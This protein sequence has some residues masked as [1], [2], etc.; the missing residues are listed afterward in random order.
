MYR[1]FVNIDF[2]GK[3]IAYTHKLMGNLPKAL[4]KKYIQRLCAGAIAHGKQQP[5]K[6]RNVIGM[7]VG[8]ENVFNTAD[9]TFKLSK[10]DLRTLAA[11]NKSGFAV[12]FYIARSKPTVFQRKHSSCADKTDTGH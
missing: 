2:K 10:G 6:S 9:F 11:V 12:M 7:T 3:L 8:K 1:Q 5:G 4:R